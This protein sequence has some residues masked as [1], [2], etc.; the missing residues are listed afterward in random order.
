MRDELDPERP[1]VVKASEL[2]SSNN[3]PRDVQILRMAADETTDYVSHFDNVRPLSISQKFGSADTFGLIYE[4][5]PS[6]AGVFVGIP[7]SEY[8]DMHFELFPATVD[9]KWHIGLFETKWTNGSCWG[10]YRKEPAKQLVS[11]VGNN[12]VFEVGLRFPPE[13]GAPQSCDECEKYD[14]VGHIHASYSRDIDDVTRSSAEQTVLR[15][16]GQP[17]LDDEIP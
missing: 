12:D 7:E 3:E 2:I 17:V 6:L 8:P 14:D 5:A 10:I 1:R 13:T 4:G 9:E 16:V 15:V 11:S